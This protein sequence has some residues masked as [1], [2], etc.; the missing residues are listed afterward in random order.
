VVHNY[1]NLFLYYHIIDTEEMSQRAIKTKVDKQIEL[2]R[3]EA[4]I[5]ETTTILDGTI[6]A[7]NINPGSYTALSAMT[8]TVDAVP[9]VDTATATVSLT[10]T[11]ITS[12]FTITTAGSGYTTAPIIS[13]SGGGGSGASATAVVT[14][15]TV[16]GITLVSGGSGYTSAPT[17]SFTGVGSGAVATSTLTGTSISSVSLTNPGWYYTTAPLV[18]VTG[19]A[20][21][22]AFITST[23]KDGKVISLN[24]VS[25]G[26]GY[27]SSPTLTLTSPVNVQATATLTLAGNKITGVSITNAGS[28]Y[29]TAPAIT[30]ATQTSTIVTAA[31]FQTVLGGTTYIKKFAWDIEPLSL[32]ESGIMR[33]LKRTYSPYVVSS[34]SSQPYK[35]SVYDIQTNASHRTI[36]PSGSPYIPKSAVLE[37]EYPF[38]PVSNQIPL[39]LAPQNINRIV[40]RIDENMSVDIGLK[41][42]TDFLILLQVEEKEPD[43]IEY[44]AGNNIQ[45]YQQQ[46]LASRNYG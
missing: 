27:T 38:N 31:T 23:I 15:G 8:I 12:T 17:I 40:L 14:S 10:G 41:S 45:T 2:Y 6:S 42:T 4:T 22:G 44:G 26:T 35:I 9:S 43:L 28:G 37:C 33:V 19:G 21:S 34:T 3:K 39:P 16:T 24:I 13:F 7:I 1:Y 30:I 25:A 11:S 46:A 29:K 5:L 32:D 36:A 18:S 20:G